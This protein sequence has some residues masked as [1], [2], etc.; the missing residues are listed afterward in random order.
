MLADVI[1]WIVTLVVL[2]FLLLLF[3]WSILKPVI[4]WFL[5]RKRNKVLEMQ[6]FQVVGNLVKTK[7]IR[8]NN[9]TKE[10]ALIFEYNGYFF[11]TKRYLK[12]DLINIV[13]SISGSKLE[14]ATTEGTWSCI[15]YVDDIL[16][17]SKG[18]IVMQSIK[19]VGDAGKMAE[20][21]S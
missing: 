4:Q 19:L 21:L 2:L 16:A 11:Q 20:Q 9:T 12:H 7:E 3:Y 5:A 17:P 6:G 8:L 15:I 1:G 18:H 14:I 13:G 10:Y